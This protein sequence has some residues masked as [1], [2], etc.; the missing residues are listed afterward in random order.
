VD[1]E[2]SPITHAGDQ[3]VCT[4]EEG[5]VGE[6]VKTETIDSSGVKPIRSPS[7]VEEPCPRERLSSPVDRKSAVSQEDLVEDTGKDNV[8]NFGALNRKLPGKKSSTR[9]GK[10]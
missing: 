8:I 6:I 1:Q 2:Q 3:L 9:R 4:T 7:E 10:K 5:M